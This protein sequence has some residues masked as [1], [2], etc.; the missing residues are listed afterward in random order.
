M[1][2]GLRLSVICTISVQ[3]VLAFPAPAL[4]ARW[5]P[6][7]EVRSAA[8]IRV[9]VSGKPRVYYRVSSGSPLTFSVTGPGRLRIVSRVEFR[10]A[11]A[12]AIAYRIRLEGEGRVWREHATE[13]SPAPKARIKESGAPVGKSRT[14]V[15][16]V[17][18]GEHVLTLSSEGTM[19]VLVRVLVAEASSRTRERM[20]SITPV[21]AVQ[22]VTV[23]EGEKLIP[24]YTVTKA[25]PVRLRIV[26]PT[27]LE[28][29][30]RL[31]F[32]PTMRGVQ[33]YKIS[34]VGA[35]RRPRTA[36]FRATKSAAATYTDLQDR[37]PSKIDRIYLDLGPGLHDLSVRLV[38]PRSGTI[39]IHARIP[40]PAMGREE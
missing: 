37:V 38:E 40:E 9:L 25:R 31:D 18:A 36:R 11:K 5:R 19:S 2:L 17:P 26:G 7:G 6:I 21:E 33:P 10:S 3:A 12:P 1:L 23:S 32:D 16:A 15:V 29:S 8:P 28:L 30:T 39:E 20:V 35:G 24:Y 34:I 22:S 4:A 27:S 13:S 14:V